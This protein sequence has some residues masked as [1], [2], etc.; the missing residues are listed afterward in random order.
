MKAGDM[1]LS[2][3]AHIGHYELFVYKEHYWGL[4]A[5]YKPDSLIQ[6]MLSPDDIIELSPLMVEM[7]YD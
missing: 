6:F 4:V 2:R 5:G 1:F 7:V 3:L